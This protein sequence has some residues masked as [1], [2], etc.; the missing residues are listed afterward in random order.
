MYRRFDEHN[1]SHFNVFTYAIESGL[2][3][4]LLQSRH[5]WA[6]HTAMVQSWRL[7][8]QLDRQGQLCSGELPSWLLLAGRWT[9]RRQTSFMC[10]P[11]QAATCTPSGVR[12]L[13][14]C[15]STG[16]TLVT[17]QHG[18]LPCHSGSY[19]REQL[20]PCPMQAGPIILGGRD[21]EVMLAGV[22]LALLAD[23]AARQPAAVSHPGR[24][25]LASACCLPETGCGRRLSML[26]AVSKLG[27][28]L[29]AQC[30]A[31]FRTSLCWVPQLQPH[32]N[33]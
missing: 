24:W 33:W 29:L 30:H 9:Q 22:L 32:T 31:D 6:R 16:Q 17:M 15:F 4:W 2:H 20:C 3:E 14:L 19:T 1:T 10:L 18:H 11:T 8:H 21:L 5:R 27:Q 12:F 23:L 13:C 7:Q 26:E 28:V 25:P